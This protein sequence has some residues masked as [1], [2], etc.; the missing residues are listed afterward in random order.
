MSCVS[1]P[2]LAK[3]AVWCGVV[4]CGVDVVWIDSRCQFNERMR[5]PRWLACLLARVDMQDRVE[6]L[7]TKCHSAVERISA[8][9][10][11]DKVQSRPQEIKW[12]T[13]LEKL[14]LEFIADSFKRELSNVILL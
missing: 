10:W 8:N 13:V 6:W 3:C 2:C 1:V 7:F 12:A 9:D 4:W 14:E 5:G 11:L